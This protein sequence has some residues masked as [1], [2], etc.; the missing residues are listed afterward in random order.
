MNRFTMSNLALMMSFKSSPREIEKLVDKLD[1]VPSDNLEV[2]SSEGVQIAALQVLIQ[3]YTSL[4]D[5]I[6]DMNRYV[7]DAVNHRAQLV[8]FPAY[9][10]MLPATILPQS[11]QILR[12]LRPQGENLMPDIRELH[13]T[14]SYFSDFV[15]DTYYHTM[16]ALAARHRIYIMA[17]SILYF[18]DSELRHR[19][20]L[21]DAN[22]D[23]IGF[24]DKIS[25]EP[26]EQE[27]RI[28]PADEI[29]VCDT[30]LGPIAMLIGSD[31][32]YF[33]VARIAK[34]LGANLLLHSTCFNREYTPIDTA[35]GLSLRI[36]ETMLYGVQSTLIGD[37]GMGFALEGPATIFAPSELMRSGGVLA[38]TS[39]R[40]EAEVLSMRLDLD[41]LATVQNAY[42]QDINP[43]LMKR[44]IDRLF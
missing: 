32:N 8:C 5:Y 14:L 6:A 41:K 35:L 25:L 3:R 31:E 23:M 20:F 38:Q 26:L 39:G 10:G 19:A 40:F 33:E 1:I 7:A 28:E 21:F 37:T 15:F 18:D 11:A 13:N 9:T 43:A 12:S 30:R 36:R 4:A 44:H 24:Q 29:K 42:I 2:V 22:G 16:S 27:L 34:S 17:G